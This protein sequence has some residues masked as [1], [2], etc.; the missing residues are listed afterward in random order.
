M[1]DCSNL[2]GISSLTRNPTTQIPE[3]TQPQGTLPPV[4]QRKEKSQLRQ[5]TH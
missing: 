2:Q 4:L 5:K 3:E 1:Q